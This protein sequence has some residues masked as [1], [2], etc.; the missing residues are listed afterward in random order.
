M[1]VSYYLC[2]KYSTIFHKLVQKKSTDNEKCNNVTIIVL[3][4][5]V[6]CSTYL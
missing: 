3:Y 2:M 4:N 5:M 6:D 1:N